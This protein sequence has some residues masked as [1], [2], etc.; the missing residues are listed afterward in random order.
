MKIAITTVQ[1]PFVRGGAEFLAENLKKALTER[2]MEAEIISMPFIDMPPERIEEHIVA[3]RLMDVNYSWGG[4]IDRCIALK[5][6]AYYMPHEDK[7]FWMLHQHRQAYDLFNTP[8]STLKDDETGKKIRSMIAAAD[9]KYLA[10]GKRIYTIAQNVSNRLMRYNGISSTALY[11]PCPDMEQFH[12]GKFED[13][14]LMPSRL[15]V[16]KRQSLAIKA[17]AAA[18]SRLKLYVVGRAESPEMKAELEALAE[19]LGV[20]DRVKFLDY[21]SQEEKIEL[22]ANARAVMFVPYDEDYGYIT[23]EAMASGKAVITAKDS[24]GPLEFVKDRETG[25]VAEPTPEG[26]AEAITKI[27]DSRDL[28]AHFGDMG[29]ERLNSMNVSWDYVVEEL[30][31]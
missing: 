15:N 23:L 29:K 22:Y 11:H 19:S 9:T 24:G 14:L 20:S 13:Y 3:S 27:E 25:F 6:P 21:V 17:L 5:F 30:T 26:I 31:K 12:D 18:K 10:E 4:H 7:V 8:F 1:I 28:A 2:G 16:T